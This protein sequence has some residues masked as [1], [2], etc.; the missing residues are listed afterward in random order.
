MKGDAVSVVIPTYNRARFIARALDS[1]L[2]QLDDKD[3]V[4]IVDDGSTDDTERV[5]AGYGNK[6]RYIRTPNQGA[7]AAR[8]RGVREARNPLLAFLDSDDMWLLDKTVIQRAFMRA[9]PGVLFSFSDFTYRV[10]DGGEEHSGLVKW[11]NDHRSWDE[12][13]GKGMPASSVM[14]L[15]PGVDDFN[16]HTGDMYLRLLF[17][18]YI[19]VNTLMVRREQAGDALHFAEGTPTYEDWEFTSRIA[20]AGKAT[21]LDIETACQD[22]H[23][24]PRLTDS[25]TTE[26]A[27]TRV[28][29]IERVYGNDPEFLR[30]H[31]A[32]YRK[33]LDEQRLIWIKGL[34]VRNEMDNAR[35]QI[36]KMMRISVKMRL[37]LLLPNSLIRF[38]LFLYRLMKKGRR[39]ILGK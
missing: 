6:V 30:I 7:G 13:L 26:C 14:K 36:K 19:N 4:I 11:S 12:I 10:A 9:M 35:E 27:K 1:C 32:S 22:N 16:F 3:E 29:I 17:A 2:S 39:M 33:V 34:I 24:G 38:L 23:G 8:N 31:G 37:L 20:R 28:E 15:P 25:H 21:Y 5:V 18:P